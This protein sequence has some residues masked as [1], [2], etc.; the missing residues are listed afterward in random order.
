MIHPNLVTAEKQATML[1]F[2]TTDAAI[3]SSALDLYLQQAVKKSFNRLTVDGDTSTNDMIL[4]MANGEAENILITD[5]NNEVFSSALEYICTELTKMMARDGEGATKL[6]TVNVNG[7]ACE[8]TAEVLAKSVV[9]S[10]LVK[11]ACFGADANWGR[12]LCALGYAG[13]DFTPEKVSVHFKS[14]VGE[15][16]VCRNGESIPFNEEKARL[17]LSGD[18]VEI[19]IS[20]EDGKAEAI[21]WGCD[22]TY[23]YVKINGDYR[24]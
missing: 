13:V 7:A 10:S 19:Y 3:S 24:S 6:L 4:V 17:I 23:D 5:N 14:G 2:I 22:L 12:V 18:E 11:A 16:E 9:S 8:H 21:S 1:A 15:V 20:L